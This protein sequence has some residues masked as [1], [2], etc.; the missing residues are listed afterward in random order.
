MQLVS[1]EV[2]LGMSFVKRR[3][4]LLIYHRIH[5]AERCTK[6]IVSSGD[7]HQSPTARA[8]TP[9]WE[10]TTIGATTTSS[11]SRI[12]KHRRFIP[13]GSSDNCGK[14]TA[15]KSRFVRHA[16]THVVN[17]LCSEMHFSIESQG[18][19]FQ[20]PRKNATAVTMMIT[21]SQVDML[22]L[23]DLK[24]ISRIA[25]AMIKTKTLLQ[26]KLPLLMRRIF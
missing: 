23:Q 6:R 15:L 18:R 19:W 16:M 24:T 3:K 5:L 2:W 4:G 26:E 14:S 1:S 21:A 20:S 25:S 13:G 17:A 9:S 11:G 8:G 12:L 22:L 7:G 10:N